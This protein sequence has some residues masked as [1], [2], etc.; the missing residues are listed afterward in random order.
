MSSQVP[1]YF[2]DLHVFL[3]YCYLSGR[4]PLYYHWEE[5]PQAELDFDNG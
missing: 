4:Q 3:Y 5:F 2:Y 1:S